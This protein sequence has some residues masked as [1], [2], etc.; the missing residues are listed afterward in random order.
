[1]KNIIRIKN[2]RN[3]TFTLLFSSCL[4]SCSD[5]LK[6]EPLSFFSPE[7][8]FVTKEGLEGALVSCR[9]MVRP[10]FI[11]NNSYTCTE[12]MT[13]D[14]AVAGNIV[15]QALK[16]FDIQLKPGAYGDSQIGTFWSKGF[17]AIQKANTVI[18][19]AQ[20]API[21]EVDKNTILAEGYFHRAYWYYKLVH[22]FGD[23]P[24]IDGE[25]T[26]P[27]LDFY[28]HTRKSILIRLKKDLNFAVLHLPD[29]APHGAVSQGAGYHLL[30]KI[31][32]ATCD[33]D[34][35]VTATSA[36]IGSSQYSLM[37]NRFGVNKAD[38]KY[39]IVSDIFA[40]ENINSTENK[41]GIFLVEDK[42][43]GR[44]HV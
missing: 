28:S 23:V 21:S 13:S 8:T 35:A 14:V 42:Q 6:P 31:C 19:R 22:Q 16:N 25:I 32:L 4:V 3:V 37:K 36:V 34:G 5:W 2:I 33:F 20:E 17:N 43:I 41:E 10:E 26:S 12:L 44:A 24:F 38:S 40:R 30:A 18:S 15:A 11:G 7:N 39:N 29:V 9:V 27:K 1:M